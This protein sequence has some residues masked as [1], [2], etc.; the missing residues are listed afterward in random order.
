M[1]LEDLQEELSIREEEIATIQEKL[2]EQRISIIN[3]AKPIIR[4]A[5]QDCVEKMVKTKA[6]HTVALGKEKVSILKSE[7]SDVLS[8]IDSFIETIYANDDYWVYTTYVLP[9]QSSLMPANRNH[10]IVDQIYEGLQVSY[11]LAGSLLQKY[12][13]VTVG[14][15]RFSEWQVKSY[16]SSQPQIKSGD[17]PSLPT[18]F[19]KLI[20]QHKDTGVDLYN[21]LSHVRSLHINIA[22]HRAEDLWNS[23]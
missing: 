10:S 8:R 18:D 20:S 1:S 11:G 15:D 5:I 21:K 22:K 23:L 7:L 12:K 13:Y 19:N 4:A 16:S 9:S 2:N 17:V 14:Y 3:G 6:E